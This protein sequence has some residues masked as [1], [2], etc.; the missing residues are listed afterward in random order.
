MICI[1][2]VFK[3][4]GHAIR[5]WIQHHIN[6]GIDTFFLTDN[7][8]T[9]T[10]DIQDYI[11]SGKVILRID[12]KKAAQ[13]EH[14]NY[15]LKDAKKY[16]W[17]IVIDLDEFIYS[18]LGY[19]TIKDYLKTVD[20]NIY[21]IQ[22]PWK[23]FGSNYLKKQPKSIIKGFTRRK[24]YKKMIVTLHDDC[25]ESKC[26]V[27]GSKLLQL[28]IHVPT[29]KDIDFVQHRSMTS[30]H[31]DVPNSATF[32]IATENILKTSCLHL[33]HYRIQSWDF[34]RK[35][36]MTRGDA[37][38]KNENSSLRDKKY[39]KKMDFNDMVDTE[40]KR[41]TLKNKSK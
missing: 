25:V 29:V 1:V 38:V 15:Y 27:R 5:E 22:L 13:E 3:N 40:L 11:D 24:R 35:V 36:K 21:L 2:S 12:A 30:D 31:T 10:Y 20:K 39:F 19:K 8:S 6:E 41:K 28:H 16:D 14:L 32:V 9:D 37:F 23:M 4:E 34:F 18:R 26:I 33:N 17:V 7:G